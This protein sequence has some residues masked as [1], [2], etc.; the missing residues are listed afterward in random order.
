M[1]QQNKLAVDLTNVKTKVATEQRARRRAVLK[2]QSIQDKLM[3]QDELQKQKA[4]IAEKECDIKRA[5]S[6]FGAKKKLQQQS[7]QWKRRFIH[8]TSRLLSPDEKIVR[9]QAANQSLRSSVTEARAEAKGALEMAATEVL[10]VEHKG[11]PAW[12][13]KL[14]TQTDRPKQC[15]HAPEL[16]AMSILMQGD[17]IK[18]SRVN[19]AVFAVL[20][21]SGMLDDEHVSCSDVQNLPD[22]TSHRRWRYGMNYVCRVQIG[23]TLTRMATDK[24]QV[25][26]GD[27]TPV[28]GRHVEGAILSTMECR[29]A[30]VPWVQASKAGRMSAANTVRYVDLCQRSYNSFY[31]RCTEKTGLPP[32]LKQGSLVLNIG[33]AVNDHAANEGCRIKELSELK[34]LRSQTLRDDLSQLYKDEDEYDTTAA[35]PITQVNCNHH[36]LMLLAKAIRVCLRSR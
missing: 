15:H 11:R 26:T 5:S 3:D 27:G 34:K 31:R 32:P 36:K 35:A 7:T 29:I 4:E 14:V 2:F 17:G 16:I 24:S 13:H 25:L 28:K 12:L 18:S 19:N 30:M 9:L 23:L 6:L 10:K 22:Q 21:Q 20:R 8:A 33:C 1:K